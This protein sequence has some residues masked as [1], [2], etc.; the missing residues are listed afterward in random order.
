MSDKWQTIDTV[1]NNTLVL[2]LTKTGE[3]DV[4]KREYKEA[5][6]SKNAG[7][8]QV[9]REDWVWWSNPYT[10]GYGCWEW[11]FAND[12]SDLTH[13]MPLPELPQ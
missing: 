3:I 13:W 10:S 5:H 2:V 12:G 6:W 8:D 9:W 11:D 4:A 7:G 1:P